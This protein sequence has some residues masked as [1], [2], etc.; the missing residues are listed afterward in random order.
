MTPPCDHWVLRKP[1]KMIEVVN[2]R[3]KKCSA[4]FLKKIKIS[5]TPNLCWANQIK[6][7]FGG[8]LEVKYGQ[9]HKSP[10]FDDF[11]GDFW[12]LCQSL[13]IFCNSSPQVVKLSLFL[14]KKQ[15]WKACPSQQ[16]VLLG[17]CTKKMQSFWISFLLNKTMWPWI[18]L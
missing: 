13:I 1:P 14:F 6:F 11:F 17:L 8:H 16:L 18:K 10:K 3:S 12:L 2:L 7:E 5:G 9:K 4:I 15:T